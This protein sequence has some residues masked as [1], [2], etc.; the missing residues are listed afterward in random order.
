MFEDISAHKPNVKLFI[1]L[2]KSKGELQ[3]IFPK[4]KKGI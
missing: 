3:N 4:F 2:K 1:Q